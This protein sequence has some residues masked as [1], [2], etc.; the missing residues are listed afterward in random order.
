[1]FLN[2]KVSKSGI[3]NADNK[4]RLAFFT[5][6]TNRVNSMKQNNTEAKH[7][8]SYKVLYTCHIFINLKN[9]KNYEFV[10]IFKNQTSQML[11]NI[12]I[13]M[14]TTLKIP[15]FLHWQTQTIRRLVTTAFNIS[16][17]LPLPSFALVCL[18]IGIGQDNSKT[19]YR[20]SMNFFLEQ[21]DTE[22]NEQTITQRQL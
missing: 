19:C 5:I 14:H 8:D 9:L 3:S 18:P 22:N 20:I 7:R 1:M 13:T 16:Q 17:L 11:Y 15:T 10:L 4:L 12:H 2:V 21:W 6:T